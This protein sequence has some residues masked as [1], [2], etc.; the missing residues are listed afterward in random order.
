MGGG[1]EGIQNPSPKQ[2]IP[3]TQLA[4]RH[5]SFAPLQLGK[6]GPLDLAEGV[7]DV[8]DYERG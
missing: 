6:C 7:E 8:E 2:L 4:S 1:A 5:I 3:G